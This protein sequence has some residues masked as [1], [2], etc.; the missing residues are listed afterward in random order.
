MLHPQMLP[1]MEKGDQRI[2]I[3]IPTG[4]VRPLEQIAVVACESQ[5]REVVCSPVLPGD[6]VLHVICVE[7]FLI[8]V[9]SEIFAD[10][11]RAGYDHAPH[12]SRDAHQAAE[13]SFRRALVC[14]RP[15]KLPKEMAL[16][17]S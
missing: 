14:N 9:G 1:G 2:A 3:W 8:L 5:V 6:D 13:F 7:W 16:W 4:E 17:Y 15:R 10:T 11:L 12:R